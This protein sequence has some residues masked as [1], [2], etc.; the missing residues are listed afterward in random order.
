MFNVY[1]SLADVDK[2]KMREYHVFF[3]Y[4][5]YNIFK[6]KE[7]RIPLAPRFLEAAK[8]LLL[9]LHFTKGFYDEV[10]FLIP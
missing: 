1:R 7:G 8:H 5:M 6:P 4:Y 10:Y 3:M 2:W 9:A